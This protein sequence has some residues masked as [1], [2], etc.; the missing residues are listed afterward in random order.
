[1]ASRRREGNVVD[2]AQ[3]T[4]FDQWVRQSYRG[5]GKTQNL[6]L[7]YETGN[8]MVMDKTNLSTKVRVFEIPRALS[9]DHAL[10]AS[11]SVTNAKGRELYGVAIQQF[12]QRKTDA[13]EIKVQQ[14]EVMSRL[15]YELAQAVGGYR[16]S[17]TAEGAKQVARAQKTMT[18]MEASF[19]DSPDLEK[20]VP[21]ALIAYEPSNTAD[22]VAPPLKPLGLDKNLMQIYVRGK[23]N[24][25]RHEILLSEVS[26]LAAGTAVGA[27]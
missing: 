19:I 24:A 8:P 21:R 3:V 10:D 26:G 9:V 14:D 4:K 23:S 27:T 1:M 5:A 6:V 13:G 25:M 2:P 22:G 11:R 12:K 7:D 18:D 20:K 15:A 17:P 16:A